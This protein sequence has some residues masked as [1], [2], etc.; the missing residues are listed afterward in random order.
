MFTYQT[1]K[2]PYAY[3]HGNNYQM[4]IHDIYGNSNLVKPTKNRTEGELI[5]ARRRALKRMQLQGIVQKHQVLENE[6]SA[7]YK[8]KILATKM[9]Y[10][11]IPPDDHRRN[12]SKKSIQTWKDYFVGVMS[13]MATTFPL[14]LWCQAIPRAEQQILLYGPVASNHGNQS[15][16]LLALV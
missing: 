4:G 6:I 2:F 10:Q 11:L 16:T 13:G 12:I 14:N 5:L 15:I 8:V 9:I 3:R 1:G 7:A